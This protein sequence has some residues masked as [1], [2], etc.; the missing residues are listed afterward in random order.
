[1]AESI[2]TNQR[3]NEKLEAY[4]KEAGFNKVI[5]LD[6]LIASHSRM[7]EMMKEMMDEKK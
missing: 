7:R 6:E 1:M 2:Q 3:V 5:T 4:S